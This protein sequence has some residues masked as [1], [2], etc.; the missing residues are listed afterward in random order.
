MLSR[1]VVASKN[2]DKAEEVKRLILAF[3]IAEEVVEGLDWPDVPELGDSLEENALAKARSVAQATRLPALA[4]DTGLEVDALDGAPGV[5]TARF[6]GDDA[7]YADNVEALLAALGGSGDRA[8]TFRTVVA[9]AHPDGR[10]TAAEGHL[11]GEIT[12]RP[13]GVSGFGYDPVFEVAGRTLAEMSGP[14]KDAISHRRRALGALSDQLAA[15]D[16]ESL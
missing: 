13:R 16:L 1:L 12:T 2:P 5:K 10:S 8:A 9:L 15:E 6:A 11:R 7:T 14:E 3:E 4:D